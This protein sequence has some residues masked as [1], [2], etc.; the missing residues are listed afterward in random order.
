LRRAIHETSQQSTR[1]LQTAPA[2]DKAGGNG[3]L[4]QKSQQSID[5]NGTK[6][7]FAGTEF[8][9]TT[10]LLK[11]LAH[12]FAVLDSAYPN[13]KL[14]DQSALVTMVQLRDE[15]DRPRGET[16]AETQIV[17]SHNNILRVRR[18][19][20]TQWH[21]VI[22]LID[23]FAN[24]R[25]QA[26]KR[27]QSHTSTSDYLFDM[28]KFSLY[29]LQLNCLM[30]YMFYYDS[31]DVSDDGALQSFKVNDGGG[32]TAYSWP[33]CYEKGNPFDTEY[34]HS[35]LSDSAVART[36]HT[37]VAEEYTCS[38][39]NTCHAVLV[40]TEVVPSN[41]KQCCQNGR[42]SNEIL[43]AGAASC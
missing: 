25:E 30:Q 19:D 16:I 42:Y 9:K 24:K 15:N 10:C 4:L 2:D 23:L 13:A 21:L 8:S 6:G 43:G 3:S 12:D 35:Q 36:M 22:G 34:D 5:M 1:H 7:G 26:W 41:M 40:K 20:G 11:A 29:P 37:A 17:D 28:K 18:D 39:I 14:V 27:F 31:Y 38:V 32:H 33:Q